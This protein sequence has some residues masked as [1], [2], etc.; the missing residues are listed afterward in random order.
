MHNTENGHDRT[1]DTCES[2]NDRPDPAAKRPE[3]MLT[4]GARLRVRHA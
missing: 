3:G 2:N 4:S 1:D